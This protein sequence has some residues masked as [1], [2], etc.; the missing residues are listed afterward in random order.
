[1]TE[2]GLLHDILDLEQIADELEQ[3]WGDPDSRYTIEQNRARILDALNKIL[4]LFAKDEQARIELVQAR[5]RRLH[6]IRKCKEG[7]SYD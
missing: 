3:A 1:M 6:E 7:G 2:S 4:T 5:I